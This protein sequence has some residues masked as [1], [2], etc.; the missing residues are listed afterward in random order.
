[1]RIPRFLPFCLGL[2]CGLAAAATPGSERGLAIAQPYRQA[3][4][5]APTKVLH[6]CYFTP[7]DMEPAAGHEERIERVMRDIQTFYR[8]EMERHGFGPA[9]FRLDEKPDGHLRLHLV[10]GAKP[11]AGY[12]YE[13]RSGYEIRGECAAALAKQGIAA[14]DQTV[15]L[16]CNL[17]A[18]DGKSIRQ[19]S[20]YYG[21]GTAFSGTAWLCDSPLL[22]PRLL[23]EKAQMVEDGQYGRISVGRY[24]SIF[25]G[26]T[27]HELGHALGLPHNRER[28]DEAARGTAL[29]GSGNRTYGEELRGEGKGSFLTFAHALRLL[30]HP[31]FGGAKGGKPGEPSLALSELAAA[32]A[33]QGFQFSG[34]VVSAVPVHAVVAYLDP[35]GGDDYDATTATAVPDTDGR[36]TLDCQALRKGTASDLRVVFCHADGNTTTRSWSFAVDKDGKPDLDCIRLPLLMEGAIAAAVGG[37]AK[38]FEAEAT[39]LRQ[40]PDPAVARILPSLEQSLAP[41]ASLKAPSELAAGQT[42][43]LAL[44]GC[45][46]E[47]QRVG[48]GRPTRNRLPEMPGLLVAGGRAWATGLYAH[49]PASHAWE[50]GGK[51]GRLRGQA[52]LAAGH[53]GSVLF[54]I[55]GDGRELWRSPLVKDGKLVTYDVD[56][57]GVRQLELAT[58][59]GPDG[60]GSDWALWLEPMLVA[61]QREPA[62]TAVRTSSSPSP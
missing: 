32:P 9:T 18:Y 48:W 1:M 20:P 3:P 34:R 10:K 40:S 21:G 42:R 8:K 37:D 61:P 62:A 25:I 23:P 55:R 19:F 11:A 47:R 13:N 53:D 49:A 57:A 5:E 7:A 14:D 35:A 26:G 36:F 46:T 6:V 41:D 27:A 43:E 28:P 31:L 44:A 12:G 17:S 33:G 58:D 51:W 38:A 52:G 60:N 2:A 39:R 50:I 56:L 54:V 16:F 15:V 24:N 22:D 45:R 30:S 59:P 29:M 4:G